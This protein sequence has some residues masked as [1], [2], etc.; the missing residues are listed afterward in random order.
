MKTN[1]M[2]MAVLVTLLL[3]A[4]CGDRDR[5]NPSGTFEAVNVDISPRLPGQLLRVGPHEGDLVAAGDTLLVIDAALISLQRAEA[6]ASLAGVAA[7]RAAAVAETAQ[8]RRSL[9]LAR[10]TL[11]RLSTMNEQGSATAQQVD[12]ARAQQD[13]LTRKV[14]A[15]EQN[16]VALDAETVRLQAGIAVRDRQVSDSVMLA[17]L[18]GTVLLRNAEPGEMAAPGAVALRLADLR[19]LELRFFLDET[20]LGLVQ[21]GQ[22]LPVKVDAFDGRA[23]TGK[24]TWI[25]SEAE[26]TPKNAQTRDARAQLVYAVKLAVANPDGDLAVGMPGE[27]VVRR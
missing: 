14:A 8:A 10:L 1:R 7:R 18:S 3:A 12:E 26:F 21:L 20:E 6:E 2:I 16:I 5:T 24:V 23:F 9:E 11:G 19:R 13:I 25:S 17:P 15:A 22:D 27:V 4:G